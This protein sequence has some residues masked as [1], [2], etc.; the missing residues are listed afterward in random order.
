MGNSSVWWME[1]VMEKIAN[2][3]KFEA[4]C[5][6]GFSRVADSVVL[7]EQPSPRV[8]LS[9]TPEQERERA[10]R[11]GYRMG[12]REATQRAQQNIRSWGL[13][14]KVTGWTQN[15]QTMNTLIQFTQLVG[16]MLGN[17][18]PGM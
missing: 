14:N 6:Q 3:S 5:N 4:L 12:F 7:G 18:V 17:M 1:V 2:I 15:P 11:R 13:W 8:N 10:Y 16:Q 9:K